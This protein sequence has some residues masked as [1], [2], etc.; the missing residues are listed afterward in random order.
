[1]TTDLDKYSDAHDWDGTPD[2]PTW[3]EIYNAAQLAEQMESIGASLAARGQYESAAFCAMACEALVE[4]QA[5]R[6]RD[7]LVA[8]MKSLGVTP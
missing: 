8:H 3:D 4:L 2:S 5:L 6:E 7:E 1:M